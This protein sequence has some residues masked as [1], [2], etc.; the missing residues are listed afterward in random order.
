MSTSLVFNYELTNHVMIQDAR[1]FS[2]TLE[3]FSYRGVCQ[4]R[5]ACRQEM[6]TS[7][8]DAEEVECEEAEWEDPN[9]LTKVASGRAAS[10]KKSHS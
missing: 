9:D 7:Q 6:A 2:R 10:S 4:F 3:L 8:K 1:T 5:T